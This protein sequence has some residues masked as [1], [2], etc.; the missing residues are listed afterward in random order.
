MAKTT[1]K[2][3]ARGASAPSK[4]TSRAVATSEKEKGNSLVS[5][6]QQRMMEEDANKGV[7]K[8]VDDNVIPLI[9][10]LQSLSP[11]ALKQKPEYIKG[12]EAG[13]IWFR[14]TSTLID[15]ENEGLLVQPCHFSKCW[16]EWMPNRGGFVARHA[17]RPAEAVLT[18]DKEN[19]KKQVWKMPNGNTVAQSREHVVL[20][21]HDSFDSPQPFVIP[22]AG[23]QHSTS[24]GWMMKMNSKNVPGTDKTAPSYSHLYR[25]FT[26]PKSNA[27]GD[28]FGWD[29]QDAGED[30][31]PLMVTDIEHYKKARKIFDDFNAGVLRAEQGGDD[32]DDA[33]GDEEEETDI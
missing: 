11:Q 32:S 9:Y 16:I 28:W 20:V 4:S 3:P 25:M 13:N 2:A 24:R 23:S 22:M 18:K 10:I 14:G 1:N 8:D 27:D 21:H 15:G 19:P 12:A 26:I 33:A 29:V 30:N 31:T 17:E 7:S 5:A 6:E